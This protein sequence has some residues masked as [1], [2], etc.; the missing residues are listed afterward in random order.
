MARNGI[1]MMFGI[2]GSEEVGGLNWPLVRYG[3]WRNVLT[4]AKSAA[5]TIRERENRYRDCIAAW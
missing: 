4:H 3:M 5:K 1:S 2:N